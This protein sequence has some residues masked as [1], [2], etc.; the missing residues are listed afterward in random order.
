MNLYQVLGCKGENTGAR[1]LPLTRDYVYG[2]QAGDRHG[3][4]VPAQYGP[5]KS[6]QR[7]TWIKPKTLGL[8]KLP[9][10]K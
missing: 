5:P 9:V 3:N 4:R 7:L 10:A 8:R 6:H 2:R 1:P